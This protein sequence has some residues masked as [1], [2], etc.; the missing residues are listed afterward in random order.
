MVCSGQGDVLMYLLNSKPQSSC[1]LC[2]EALSADRA[3]EHQGWPLGSGSNALVVLSD[4]DTP[5]GNDSRG[6]VT[7]R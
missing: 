4:V 1:G 3:R 2:G 5:E 6:E 7:D